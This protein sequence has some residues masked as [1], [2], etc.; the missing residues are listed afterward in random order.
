MRGVTQQTIKTQRVDSIAVAT[1]CPY[2]AL[3][4]GMRVTRDSSVISGDEEFPVNN[5]ALCVKGWTAAELLNHPDRL[6][7]PLKR[8]ARGVLGPVSWDEAFETVA[9]AFQTTQA[10]HGR[11]AVGVLGGGSLTN[12]KAYLVGKFARVALRTANIDYNGRFCMSS[13]AAASIKAF[14]ID[15]GLPFP[16][17]D[18]AR[19]EV[20]LL[21]GANPAETM[22]PLMQYFESGRASGG[23]LMVAD[24]RRTLT[25]QSAQLH[26]RLIPG[27]DAAL[28]GGLLHILI[29]DGLIDEEYIRERTEG[30]SEAKAVAATYWPDRVERI[31]GVAE[32]R[33]I[34]AAHALGNARS[35][36]ILTAR[37]PEQQSQGVN[38]AL[39]FINLALALGLPGRPFSGFGSITGQG[40][41]QG[42]REHGQKADQLPGYRR[43]DDPEA[44]SHVARVWGVEESEIPGAG[45]SANELLRSL[46]DDIKAL[47][48]IGFNFA[49]SAPDAGAV[50]DRAERLDF[51]CAGDF[52][53]SETARM[54]DVVLPAA[55]WAEEEG[56][57]TNLEG[58]VIR[59]RRVKQPPPDVKSDIEIMCELA[60][61]LGRGRYFRYAS[62][63]E[64]FNEMRRASQGGVADYSGVT[65]QKIE[66]NQGVYWPCPDEGRPGT[67]RLFTELFPTPSGRAR[68]HAVRHAA[69]DEE[70]D[71]E[72]P[73]FL[74]TGR[75]L[76]HYQSGA[77]TRR[78]AKLR[79]MSADPQAEFHPRA[80]FACGL[81]DGETVNLVT[82]R[83]SATFKVKITPGARED[84]VF[85][86]FHWG[87]EQ[88]VNRLTN[89]ALDPVSRMPEF[90][91]CAVRVEKTEK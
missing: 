13:A 34:E 72:Y 28:A 45:K 75:V 8:N 85:V 89:A 3:Q 71:A 88:S 53:L 63:E 6:L 1:H 91:V 11:D 49:V 66:A 17:A 12:E 19:A 60:A 31:T 18:I 47:F 86:P 57:M 70:T 21:V 59:R 64:I 35:A 82:R 22:P 30:F 44:R 14:G 24:P 77:Q 74:T 29:R 36:M 43:I 58:R 37:G 5:G 50:I 61:R 87:D 55:M 2:C 84:T 25:A 15:R 62:V 26:L 65:W 40:N 90:K 83:G 69:P 32:G 73:L 67:P 56:T 79:E 51:L 9:E 78:V 76:A 20:I 81:R 39:A 16:V 23:Q 46:G 10:K 27:T 68:F 80:A 38:N 7:R 4:C 42:G 48:T 33:L 52:F 54:A 41:G